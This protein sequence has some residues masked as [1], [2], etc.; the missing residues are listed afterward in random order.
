ME[1]ERDGQQIRGPGSHP[2]AEPQNEMEEDQN[3]REGNDRARPDSKPRSA[4]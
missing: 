3:Q 2:H 4:G 1:Q